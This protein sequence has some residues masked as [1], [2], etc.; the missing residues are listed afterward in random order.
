MS[1]VDLLKASDVDVEVASMGPPQLDG[2]RQNTPLSRHTKS[3]N[4]WKLSTL[5]EW[6]QFPIQEDSMASQLPNIYSPQGSQSPP[7]SP[8]LDPFEW[9]ETYGSWH[10]R[11]EPL[12]TRYPHLWN[13]LKGVMIF[14]DTFEDEM[15]NQEKTQ[16]FEVIKAEVSS[17]RIVFKHRD[18]ECPGC[19]PFGLMS[20]LLAFEKENLNSSYQPDWRWCISEISKSIFD[21]VIRQIDDNKGF[22][23]FIDVIFASF[24]FCLV[25]KLPYQCIAI[26]DALM[27]LLKFYQP[28]PFRHKGRYLDLVEYAIQSGRLEKMEFLLTRTMGRDFI[29]R[30][31][32]SEACDTTCSCI[33]FETG[34]EED[35]LYKKASSR[36]NIIKSLSTY[37]QSNSRITHDCTALSEKEDYNSRSLF[38]AHFCTADLDC[39]SYDPIIY[40]GLWSRIQRMSVRASLLP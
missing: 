16:E 24:R 4:T 26:S 40:Q 31:G 34:G 20:F 9:W 6:T 15:F 7:P 13:I 23:G 2:K 29:E 5:G 25:W 33:V 17:S 10:S 14:G 11:P 1:T 39:P 22:E 12:I 27:A 3:S 38:W 21:T 8:P 32:Q 19:R 28:I 30:A 35:V 37:R 18:R 36:L